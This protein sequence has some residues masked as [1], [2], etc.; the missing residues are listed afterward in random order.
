MVGLTEGRPD[1]IHFREI[2]DHIEAGELQ[3]SS[4]N[5]ASIWNRNVVS[6]GGRAWD[7]RASANY[8]ERGGMKGI[9][10]HRR[11]KPGMRN[12]K[13]P[14]EAMR[15]RLAAADA[16]APPRELLLFPWTVAAGKLELVTCCPFEERQRQMDEPGTNGRRLPDV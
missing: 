2:V 9:D 16:D 10:P 6:F 13:R 12:R 1:V 4:L 5:L 7:V 11:M 3:I 14:R 8:S 15:S